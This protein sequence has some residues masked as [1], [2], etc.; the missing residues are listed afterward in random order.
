MTYIPNK[1]RYLFSENQTTLTTGSTI[2]SGWLDMESVDKI[3][4][5]I[6]SDTSGLNSRITSSSLP[7]GSGTTITSNTTTV[8]ALHLVNITTRQRYMRFELVNNSTGTTTNN[9][10]SIKASFGSADKM[11]VNA[12]ISEP[13]DFSQAGLV[14]AIG[15]GKQPDGNYVTVPADGNAIVTTTPLISGDTYVSAWIDTDGWKSGELFIHTDQA[16]S[17]SGLLIEYTLDANVTTPVI[18]ATETFTYSLEDTV[19]G[20]FLLKFAPILNGCRISYTNG[21]ITQTSFELVLSLRVDAVQLSQKFSGSHKQN[22]KN[23]LFKVGTGQEV[24]HTSDTQ[25]GRNPDIDIATTPEDVWEG[26][27]FYTGQPSQ[28]A[29]AETIDIISSSSSDINSGTGARTIRLYGLDENWEEQEEDV[30]LS[31]TTSSVTTGLW[32]RM[33]NMS[34]LTAGSGGQN[35]GTITARHTTTTANVFSVMSPTINQSSI[36]AYTVPLNKTM[37]VLQGYIAI[38]RANGADGSADWTFRVRPSGGV[39]NSNRYS[40]VTTAFSTLEVPR[41]T[42]GPVGE[43]T[44]IKVCIEGVSDNNT[45]AAASFEYMNINDGFI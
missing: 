38:G 2:D 25:F 43:K 44:D 21:S 24:G 42:I 20:Y 6:L 31:G 14:Q 9:S 7:N 41:T 30:I 13:L 37:F 8:G 11:T 10:L 23:F 28:T 45:I 32:H 12:S 15:K 26:G 34:V 16:S 1:S 36:A 3:Q 4:L 29:S 33:N 17:I 18:A 22:A 35:A 19:N 5:E 39:F 40:T 27:G